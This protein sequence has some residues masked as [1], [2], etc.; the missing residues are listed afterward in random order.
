MV[1]TVELRYQNGKRERLKPIDGFLL[2]ELTPAH[3][4]RG[5]RLVAAVALNRSGKAISTQ[6][7]QPQETGV[8]PCK[9]SVHRGYGVNTCP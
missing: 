5:T 3:Y 9:K 1:A 2:H 7:F 8:Y 6:R 4:E